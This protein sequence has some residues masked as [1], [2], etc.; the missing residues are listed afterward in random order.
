MLLSAVHAAVQ[1]RRSSRLVSSH[2]LTRQASQPA[3]G[4]TDG[5][6]IARESCMPAL[7]ESAASNATIKRAL[8]T[9]LDPKA[10]SHEATLRHAPAHTAV[11]APKELLPGLESGLDRFRVLRVQQLCFECFHLKPW[12]IFIEVYFDC[13][14]QYERFETS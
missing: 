14:L 4:V 2:E 8:Q 11:Q 7:L 12:I 6:L 1:E 5:S 9:A 10:I 13:P 3:R